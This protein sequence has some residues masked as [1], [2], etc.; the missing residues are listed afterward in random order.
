M[1]RTDI[2]LPPQLRELGEESLQALPLRAV[3]QVAR[4]E[5]GESRLS[6]ADLMQEVRRIERGEFRPEGFLGGVRDRGVS[7]ETFAR[8]RRLV[9]PLLDLG[10]VPCLGEELEGRLEIIHIQSD[11]P[12]ETCEAL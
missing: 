6:L 5:R 4:A 3:A 8:C 1:G 10:P 11:H 12:I 2:P 7:Q 9:I